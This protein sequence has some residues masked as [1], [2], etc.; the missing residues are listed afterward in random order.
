MVE[1]SA[2][3]RR[4]IID[5]LRRGTVPQHGLDVMAVGLTRFEAAI[6]ADGPLLEKLAVELMGVITDIL[7]NLADDPCVPVLAQIT[8]AW[9]GKVPPE[10]VLEDFLPKPKKASARV[11]VERPD[12]TIASRSVTLGLSGGGLVQ[13]VDGLKVGERVVTRGSLFIDRAASGDKAS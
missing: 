4:D 1:V 7:N 12:G 3:R 5:A 13:V 10:P 9:G 11:W 6:D 8:T 2:R